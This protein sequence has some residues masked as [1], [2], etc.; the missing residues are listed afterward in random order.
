[1]LWICFSRSGS[2]LSRAIRW[3]TGGK[4]SHAYL[5]WEEPTLG[6]VRMEAGWSGYHLTLAPR[7]IK[8]FEIL[9]LGEVSAVHREVALPLENDYLPVVRRAASW[10]GAPY[11]YTGAAG[12]LWTALGNAVSG[13]WWRNPLSSPRALFCSEAIA[14]VLKDQGHKALVD[15]DPSTVSPQRLLDLLTQDRL[16]LWGL[17]G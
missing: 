10:L 2:L 6:W 11:D 8:D 9:R 14:Q 13:R 7:P 1:M 16:F 15:V 3:V 17:R 4:F 5:M 12:F